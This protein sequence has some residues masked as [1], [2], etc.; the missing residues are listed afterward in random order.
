VCLRTDHA[1]YQLRI[2]LPPNTPQLAL[3]VIDIGEAFKLYVNGRLLESVD[4]VYLLSHSHSNKV[5]I[6]FIGY[7][8]FR[9]VHFQFGTPVRIQSGVHICAYSLD[10]HSVVL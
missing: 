10:W 1:S 5:F 8:C 3:K 2:L 4:T 9:R 6:V 7:T